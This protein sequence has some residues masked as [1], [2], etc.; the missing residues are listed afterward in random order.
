MAFDI[1]ESDI[2]KPLSNGV[3]EI[4]LYAPQSAAGRLPRQ[5]EASLAPF[6]GNFAPLL[7]NDNQVEKFLR[8]IG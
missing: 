1:D 5:V 4:C 7:K 2:L 8:P 6:F 3:T